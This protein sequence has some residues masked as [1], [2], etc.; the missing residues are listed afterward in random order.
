MTEDAVRSSDALRDSIKQLSSNVDTAVQ[1]TKEIERYESQID[2]QHFE[3]RKSFA[4][5]TD[6]IELSSTLLLL[7][8]LA[9][10]I[11]RPRQ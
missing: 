6:R 8:E 4:K 7:N 3:I 2:K 1:K 11:A 5:Y 10:Y 9:G